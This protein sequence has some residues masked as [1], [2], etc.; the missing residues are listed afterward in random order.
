MYAARLQRMIAEAKERAARFKEMNKSG[1]S[2]S[3]IGKEYGI[4]QGRVR[5]V[6]KKQCPEYKI[7]NQRV[8]NAKIKRDKVITAHLRGQGPDEIASEH[9]IPIAWV[10]TAIRVHERKATSTEVNHN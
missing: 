10:K 4:S 7:I 6:L 1:Y 9:E 3:E 5:Q 2:L 8:N